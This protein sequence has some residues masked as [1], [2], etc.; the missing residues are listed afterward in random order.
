MDD[1]LLCRRPRPCRSVHARTA[2]AHHGL[3]NAG[4][5]AIVPWRSSLDRRGRG[6]GERWDANPRSSS[7]SRDGHASRGGWPRQASQP[8]CDGRTF[9]HAMGRDEGGEEW[10][11]ASS[12]GGTGA[13]R[14]GGRSLGVVVVGARVPAKADQADRWADFSAGPGPIVRRDGRALSQALSLPLSLP[15]SLPLSP[16][17]PL[18]LCVCACACV[19][20]TLS[21]SAC[22]GWA[23]F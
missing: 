5:G 6:V 16:P 13:Y 20:V 3:R 11:R 8:T 10:R 1:K 23:C 14:A 2:R 12:V 4:G 18:S 9:N 19:Y 17:P 22:P 21:F 7:A 15:P